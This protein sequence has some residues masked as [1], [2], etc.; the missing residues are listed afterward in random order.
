MFGRVARKSLT[1][2]G[3]DDGHMRHRLGRLPIGPNGLFWA[4]YQRFCLSAPALVGAA[5]PLG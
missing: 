1:R 2:A 3:I 5:R 4:F